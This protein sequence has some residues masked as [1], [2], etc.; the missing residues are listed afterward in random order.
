MCIAADADAN[1]SAFLACQANSQAEF[2]Y[3]AYLMA[4][5]FCYQTLQQLDSTAAQEV[6]AGV[7]E[8]LYD[9]LADYDR[10]FPGAVQEDNFIALTNRLYN[11]LRSEDYV[12]PSTGDLLV[13]WYIQEIVL[14]TYGDDNPNRF[15]PYDETKVDLSGIVNAKK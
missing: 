3:S 13:S 1:L 9:D 14:P 15:D 6:N 12:S 5:R 8:R 2:Q 4:Y 7:S 10:F 11:K